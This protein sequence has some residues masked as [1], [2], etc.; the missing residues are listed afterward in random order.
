MKT[1]L[2]VVAMA[3]YGCAAEYAWHKDRLPAMS[4]EWRVVSRDKL[5]GVCSDNKQNTGACAFNIEST[6]KCWIYSFLTEDDADR[7][8]SAD[9][10]TLREHELKHCAGYRHG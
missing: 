10:I 1:A 2:V 5:P 6:R 7:A 8:I 9:G 3:L 4:Y